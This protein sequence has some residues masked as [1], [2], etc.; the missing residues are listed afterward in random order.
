MYIQII[1][2]SYYV[3]FLFFLILIVIRHK[4]DYLLYFKNNIIW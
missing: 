3:S 1:L 2:M 4:R